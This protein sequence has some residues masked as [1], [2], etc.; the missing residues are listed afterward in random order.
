[1]TTEYNP[2][3]MHYSQV[4]SILY[5]EEDMFKFIGKEGKH[6]KALTQYLKINY[7]W[8]NKET[9][10]IELWGPEKRLINAQKKMIQKMTEYMNKKY[11]K[12]N[13]KY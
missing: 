3:N 4:K 9:N 7:I 12:E 1:M 13:E 11:A 10:I 8:W 2:P 5:T 6:F